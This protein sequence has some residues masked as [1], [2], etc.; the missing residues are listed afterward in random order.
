MCVFVNNKIKKN[1]TN[2]NIIKMPLNNDMENVENIIE[3]LRKNPLCELEIRLGK[4]QGNRFVSG[5]D[6]D[7]FMDIHNDLTSLPS[8][9]SD[10]SWH[11]IMDVFYVY[12]KIEY[13]TRVNYSNTHMKIFATTIKKEKIK[14]CCV[15]TKN[16]SIR[17]SLSNEKPVNHE[18][19][20]ALVN[21]NFVRLKHTKKFYILKND[22]KVWCIEMNKVWGAETRT[23]VEEK[24]HKEAPVY[25]IEC[26]LV[27]TN[28]YLKEKSNKHILNSIIHKG[29]SLLGIPDSNYSF[30]N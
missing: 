21:P 10:E 20:P 4:K 1:K 27:D 22:V 24:Q 12:N 3:L 23:L 25:E 28:K 15:N 7:T 18:D 11:E 17:I 13:R 9:E 30:E 2:Q 8:L 6:R 16:N 26:E 19:I 29:L 14:Q 5:V